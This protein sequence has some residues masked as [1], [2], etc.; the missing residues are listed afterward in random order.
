MSCSTFPVFLVLQTVSTRSLYLCFY[1][2]AALLEMEIIQTFCLLGCFGL[3]TTLIKQV[4]KLTSFCSLPTSGGW[5]NQNIMYSVILKQLGNCQIPVPWSRFRWDA[6]LS[7]E[8]FPPDPG[9][10]RNVL[11][12][13]GEEPRCCARGWGRRRCCILHNLQLNQAGKRL[14][15]AS[16]SVSN[17]RVLS[18]HS[19]KLEHGLN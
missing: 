6:R 7:A 2:G 15:A 12:L 16:S 14:S 1:K 8:V 19:K 17:Y 10:G 11:A 13:P 18:T 3:V 5:M 9:R 4:E